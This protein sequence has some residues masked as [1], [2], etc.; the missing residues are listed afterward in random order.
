[1]APPIARDS[2]NHSEGGRDSTN[3]NEGARDST[4]QS[5]VS[6]DQSQRRSSRF[7]QSEPSSRHATRDGIKGV[8]LH[9]SVFPTTT[10][11]LIA[12]RLSALR[13]VEHG[14]NTSV[15]SGVT[16]TNAISL[17]CNLGT[18]NGGATYR[19]RFNQSEPSSRH[20]TRGTA[21]G[22]KG[23]CLHFSAFPSTP[24]FRPIT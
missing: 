2:T 10:A 18:F 8:C 6:D 22:I 12:R 19:S 15:T 11:V 1:M 21:D 4:N 17:R 16:F 23:V 20:A 24:Q 14:K 5:R 7:N 3:H 9:F 13:I